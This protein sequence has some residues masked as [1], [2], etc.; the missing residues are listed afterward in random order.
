[1]K[2][3]A[4]NMRP[5]TI[6]DVVGQEHLLGQ[7]KII[8]RMV[9]SRI[10]TSM[11]LYGPPGIGKTSIASALSGST[12]IPFE[13]FNA[14]TD[15]KTKL[16]GFAKQIDKTD[17]PIILLLDEIHRLDKPKQDFLLPYMESGQMIIIGATTENPYISVNPAIRSRSQIFELK[18]IQTNA[19]I[20]LIDKALSTD[21]YGLKEYN[22]TLD[23]DAKQFLARVTNGDARSMLTA[24][25]IAIKSTPAVGGVTPITLEVLEECVQKKHIR[26]DK[27]GDAHYDTISALQK[28]IRGSDVN[29]SL[30]Y[31][32]Q[33]IE[34]GDMMIIVRRL[35]VI[36]YE[37]VGLANP[38]MWP[39]VMAGIQAAER[40]GFPEARIPLS[41]VV[42]Q[43]ALSPKSNSAYKAIDAALDDIKKHTNVE[44]PA[45]LKDAHYKG[46]AKLGHGVNYQ[47]PHDYEHALVK[48]QYLP[49]GVNSEYL[50]FKQSPN[51]QQLSQIYN[52]IKNFQDQ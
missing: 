35:T 7:G 31:L 9:Q 47:Y 24:L 18:P 17:Q 21:H 33:L 28:S 49:D 51:E 5:T 43:L 44:I 39:V 10:L 50:S 36:C 29:A 8:R 6:D 45:H 34:T 37:D 40:V 25:E 20:T 26:G 42:V 1:M 22:A 19:M 12:G 15:A 11:I 3:L 23:D 27:D 38:L 41:A 13:Y 2:N 14:S 46:A 32:A 4:Y 16:Q 48:Q 52:N 30:Y